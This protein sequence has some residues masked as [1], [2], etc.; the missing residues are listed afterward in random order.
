MAPIPVFLKTSADQPRPADPEFYWVTQDGT[1]LCRNHEF[2]A[3]DVPARRQPRALA[4][5]RAA[6]AVNYPKLGA[7]A[8]EVVVG[9]FDQVFAKHRSE[10]VV[11]LL[12]NQLT[13][14]YRI[15]VP[16]QEATVWESRYG[17]RSP[18][19]VRYQLPGQLP[20]HHLL[21]GDIHSHG[22]I[23]AYASA[24]DQADERHRDGVHGIIGHIDRE[25]PSF[26][27]ELAVDGH[28]FP[29]Q[30][31]QFYEGYGKRR[32][33]VPRG[34]LDLVKVKVERSTWVTWSDPWTPKPRPQR[35]AWE[36]P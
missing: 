27:Q 35:K 21:V 29:L 12:W 17:N 23:S 30:F 28:R 24:T 15:W 10:A 26:H 13:Q 9:F 5:H 3:S 14:R 8:L 25:P 32:T 34:W 31:D 18:T 4:P 33:R 16:E 19:D 20:P 11:L 2:F 7:K 1:F 6:C 22:D 36:W